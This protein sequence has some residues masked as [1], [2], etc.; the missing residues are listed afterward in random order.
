MKEANDTDFVM[1]KT[2]LR[3][4]L[5]LRCRMRRDMVSK[6]IGNGGSRFTHSSRTCLS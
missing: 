4:M 2:K 1:R 5:S 3:S 6:L